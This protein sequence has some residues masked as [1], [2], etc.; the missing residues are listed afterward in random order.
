MRSSI[1]NNELLVLLAIMRL[2]DRAY[3]VPIVN[4][5]ERCGRPIA[6]ASVYAALERL[7]EKGFVTSVMSEP[8]PERGGKA[9]RCFQLT[10]RGLRE[11]RA[12]QRVL[13]KLL[14][15]VPQLKGRTV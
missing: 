12:M 8:T 7:E 4:E 5:L 1:G 11:V 15:G 3:G 13:G 2:D 9:R 14:Q 10:G 6:V